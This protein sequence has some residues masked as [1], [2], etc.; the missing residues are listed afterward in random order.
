MGEGKG[1]VGSGGDRGP[2]T[3]VARAP[4]PYVATCGQL[5]RCRWY[6]LREG[7]TL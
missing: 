2:G 1:K 5:V 6:V 4:S 7:K 3:R